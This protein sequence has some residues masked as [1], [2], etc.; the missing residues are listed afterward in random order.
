MKTIASLGLEESLRAMNDVAEDVENYLQTTRIMEIRKRMPAFT[1]KENPA[2]RQVMLDEQ[3]K[4]NMKEIRKTVLKDHVK[5]TAEL[6][7]KL[8]VP[9]EGESIET[10]TGAD[11]MKVIMEVFSD[12]KTMDFFVSLVRLGLTVSNV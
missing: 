10:M 4:K 9:E 6:V 12:R 3:A 1:G 5:E 7:K 11:V 8:C 2:L